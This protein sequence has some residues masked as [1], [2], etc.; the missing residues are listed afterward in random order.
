MHRHDDLLRRA[1]LE[2]VEDEIGGIRVELR[3][4]RQRNGES[5]QAEQNYYPQVERNGGLGG[6]VRHCVK[7]CHVFIFLSLSFS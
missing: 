2:G 6:S 7:S 5:E 3:K 1:S 4:D